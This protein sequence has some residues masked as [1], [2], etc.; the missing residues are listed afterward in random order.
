MHSALP[1]PKQIN[2]MAH[3][4]SRQSLEGYK[5]ESQ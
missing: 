4:Q 1:H 3:A 2:I 5:L